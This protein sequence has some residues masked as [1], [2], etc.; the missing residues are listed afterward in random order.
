MRMT[1]SAAAAAQDK[2]RTASSAKFNSSSSSDQKPCDAGIV[3]IGDEILNGQ[4]KDVN[5][6]FLAARLHSL[7]IR[8]DF[9]AVAVGIFQYLSC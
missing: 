5:T 8:D 2:G 9:R 1:Q 7:G 4:T 6:A 3:I